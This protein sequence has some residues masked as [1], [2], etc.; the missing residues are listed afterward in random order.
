MLSNIYIE[1][2]LKIFRWSQLIV[3]IHSLLIMLLQR[4]SKKCNF[5]SHG[6]EELWDNSKHQIFDEF[7]WK[8]HEEGH[9]WRCC[10]KKGAV[11]KWFQYSWEGKEELEDDSRDGRSLISRNQE[12]VAAVRNLVQRNHILTVIKK[13]TTSYW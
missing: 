6:I 10:S 4:S 7:D 9:F 11:Y 1:W 12:M 5:P 3:L 13:A 2:N 8:T